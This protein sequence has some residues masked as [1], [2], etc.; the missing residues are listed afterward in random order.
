MF[1]LGI[2]GKDCESDYN[3]DENVDDPVGPAIY[4]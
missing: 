2:G 4:V 3:I 1:S